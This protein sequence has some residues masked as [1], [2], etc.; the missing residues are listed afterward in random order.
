MAK[1]LS[2]KRLPLLGAILLAI[3]LGGNAALAQ[4]SQML[5]SYSTDDRDRPGYSRRRERGS[6]VRY[7]NTQELRSTATE[8]ILCFSAYADTFNR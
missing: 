1:S 7:F 3:V 4:S 5:N 2:Q 6:E 8:N